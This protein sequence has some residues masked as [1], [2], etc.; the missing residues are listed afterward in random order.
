MTQGQTCQQPRR[1]R[2]I[3]VLCLCATFVLSAVKI[4][5]GHL[6]KLLTVL[7][8]HAE[9]VA[10]HGHSHGLEGDVFWALQGHAHGTGDHEHVPDLLPVSAGTLVIAAI[11][12]DRGRWRLDGSPAPVFLIDR[13]PRA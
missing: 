5:M 6:P 9:M 8:D 12:Q 7:Y 13:P 11:G 1:W 4:D 10:D 3:V 2:T